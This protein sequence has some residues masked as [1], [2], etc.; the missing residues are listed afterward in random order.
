MTEAQFSQAF[1]KTLDWT[2]EY[3]SD[4][5]QAFSTH[6]AYLGGL[7]HEPERDKEYEGDIVKNM[8]MAQTYTS[9][10][11]CKVHRY[12]MRMTI[13]RSLS[14]VSVEEVIRRLYTPQA[15]MLDLMVDQFRALAYDGNRVVTF[16]EVDHSKAIE[17]SSEIILTMMPSSNGAY[18]RAKTSAI[19]GIEAYTQ[20]TG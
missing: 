8:A 11:E 5:H 3:A 19:R 18:T 9:Y 6:L 16:E 12:N 20:W 7:F 17:L 4:F 15:L 1:M 14:N 2:G 13:S 10:L